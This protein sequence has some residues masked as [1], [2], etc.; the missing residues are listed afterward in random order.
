MTAALEGCEW[1]A[2]RPGRMLSPGKTRYSFYRSLGGPQAQSGR[3]EN[4]VSTWFR[5]RTVQPV[6]SRYTDWATRPT[7][8]TYNFVKFKN[9]RQFFS[10]SKTARLLRLEVW[11]T[12]NCTVSLNFKAPILNVCT[13]HSK[14]TVKYNSCIVRLSVFV[15]DTSLSQ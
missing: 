6:V 9:G 2:A 15:C 12:N 8:I 13:K 4:L 1:S 11:D 14:P 7:F 10:L 5:S 3:A